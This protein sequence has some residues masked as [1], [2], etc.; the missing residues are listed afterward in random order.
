MPPR[1]LKPR[2]WGLAASVVALL[3]AAAP[4]AAAEPSG[5]EAEA[6]AAVQRTI[7]Q[8]LAV[9]EDAELPSEQKKDRVEA[10]AEKRFD[11]H[12]VA[13][14][15]AA[16]NWRK[17]SEAQRGEFTRLFRRHLSRTYRDGLDRYSGQ[18]VLLAG[19]RL[20]GN[21]DVTVRTEIRDAGPSDAVRVDYRLRKRGDRWLGIDLIVEGVSLLQNFR[22]QIQ[23]IVSR[24]GVEAALESLRGKEAGELVA[25]GGPAE[26]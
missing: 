7:D 1:H 23:E 11:F 15:V 3:A 18:R 6:R 16:R 2:S 4:S 10:L 26:S 25:P 13:R 24:G 5:A 14:L 9:L 17:F 8:V 22:S 21:G 20:E 12:L 19:S